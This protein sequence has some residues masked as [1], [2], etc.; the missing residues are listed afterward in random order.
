MI[1]T[2]FHRTRYINDRGVECDIFAEENNIWI[3]LPSEHPMATN[4][5]ITVEIDDHGDIQLTRSHITSRYC[6]YKKNEIIVTINTH[7]T[8]QGAW[9][10]HA[11]ITGIGHDDIGARN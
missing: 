6:T 5:D 1:F 3:T 10:E 4:T 8:P 11:C 2:L 7:F 9:P